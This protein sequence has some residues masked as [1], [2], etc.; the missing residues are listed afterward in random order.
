[1]PPGPSARGDNWTFRPYNEGDLDGL[2][3]LHRRVFG[4]TISPAQWRWKLASQ[5]GPVANVWVAE[6]DGRLVFQYAGIPA[7]VRHQAADRW[8][9]IDVDTM[10]D[11]DYRRRGL[12]TQGGARTYRSWK[13]AGIAFT[14]GLPNEQWG[15]RTKAL[16]W[17]RLGELRWWVRWL[18]PVRLMAAR[19]GVYWPG[20]RGGPSEETENGLRFAAVQDPSP[21][22][23]LWSRLC[24]EGVIRNTAWFRWRYLEAVP[25]WTVLAAWESRELLGCVA[26]HLDERDRRSGLIGEV[27]AP[28]FEVSRLLLGQSCRALR[29]M[30]AS[31]AALLVQSRSDLEE[32][33]LSAG[34]LPR[35]W[36]FSIEAVDLGGGLPWTAQFQG[37]D[38]DVV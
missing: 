7:R 10:T 36:S 23:D 33:A 34:F 9:M 16:G 26:F 27:L 12:L 25:P 4:R 29:R 1:M 24:E 35:R 2:I 14:F 11:P 17:V 6:A 3:A 38:F 21:I 18:D 37:G 5:P 13:E 30:G 22:D 31:R 8:A 28:S 20:R 32:A 15:S 19:A